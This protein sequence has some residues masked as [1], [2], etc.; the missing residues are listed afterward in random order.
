MTEA[1]VEIILQRAGEV[2]QARP[3]I[4]SDNGPQFVP[5]I[6]RNSSAVSGMTHVRTSR[7]TAEQRQIERWHGSLKRE[8]IRPG[9]PLSLEDAG[10][11]RAI[12]DALQRDSLHSA[13]GFVSPKTKLEGASARSSPHA[14][15]NSKRRARRAGCDARR[16]MRRKKNVVS[17]L[18]AMRD[19]RRILLT[20]GESGGRLCWRATVKGHP[21]RLSNH[22]RGRGGP[23]DFGV[24]PPPSWD[25]RPVLSS[26]NAS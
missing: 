1:Q 22:E 26:K 20:S 23:P 8:C 15:A 25:E 4:I 2:P 9:T 6:S 14:T 11:G 3:R 5:G 13:L 10:A 12:R 21:I 18:F 7:T 19:G 16:R 24:S 17:D